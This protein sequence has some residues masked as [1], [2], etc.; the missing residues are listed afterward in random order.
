[1]LWA[2]QDEIGNQW[3]PIWSTWVPCLRG[4]DD[5][6]YC[7]YSSVLKRWIDKANVTGLAHHDRDHTPP[8]HHVQVLLL[9]ALPKDV[10]WVLLDI[11]GCLPTSLDR[12]ILRRKVQVNCVDNQYACSTTWNR[13]RLRPNLLYEQVLHLGVV[14]L[15]A[16]IRYLSLLLPPD[17]DARKV[18]QYWDIAMWQKTNIER[19][20]GRVHQLI[21]EPRKHQQ[22]RPNQESIDHQ[23]KEERRVD[24]RILKG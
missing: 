3:V 15:L 23:S 21:W 22:R 24:V 14:L 20:C 9:F 8:L 13:W 16:R 18:Y 12:H 2:N 17:D 5:W 10:H 6:I 4:F 7:V 19:S 1:M 11:F